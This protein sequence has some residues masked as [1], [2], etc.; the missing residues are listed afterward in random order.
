MS[1]L[2]FVFCMLIIISSLLIPNNLFSVAQLNFGIPVVRENI[3]DGDY[4]VVIDVDEVDFFQ[5]A[6]VPVFLCKPLNG[7]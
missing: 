7:R 1:V 5:D 3:S 4:C 2:T 6:V